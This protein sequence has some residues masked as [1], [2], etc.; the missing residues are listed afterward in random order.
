VVELLVEDDPDEDLGVD[1][2]AGD[3]GV[4]GLLTGRIEPGV[5]EPTAKFVFALA[6][7]RRPVD[8]PSL[9]RAEFP[10]NHLEDVADGHPRR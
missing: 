8:A 1:L 6:K 2:L 7:E 4:H 3:T 9:H 5:L 10:A